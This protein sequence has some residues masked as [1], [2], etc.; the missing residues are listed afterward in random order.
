METPTAPT[1]APLSDV[2]F[3]R[4]K[5][6]A[7]LAA[8]FIAVEVSTARDVNEK[9]TDYILRMEKRIKDLEIQVDNYGNHWASV[10]ANASILRKALVQL[11]GVETKEELDQFERLMKIFPADDADRNACIA[12]IQAIRDTAP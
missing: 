6:F 9:V 2:E 10:S 7:A 12:A 5:C 3:S 8:L 11:V 4:G 1:S